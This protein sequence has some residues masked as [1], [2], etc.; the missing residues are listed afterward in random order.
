MSEITVKLEKES[1]LKRIWKFITFPFR[2]G[3]ASVILLWSIFIA[4]LIAIAWVLQILVFV[5]FILLALWTIV[6]GLLIR[7][8]YVAKFLANTGSEIVSYTGQKT[9]EVGGII[10]ELGEASIKFSQD[11]SKNLIDSSVDIGKKSYKKAEWT[12]GVFKKH[13]TQP[14]YDWKLGRQIRIEKEQKIK[15]IE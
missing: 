3:I 13:I 9:V 6:T 5:I 10:Y 2:L 14:Y 15:N 4:I 7:S 11:L 12:L 1:K 8:W